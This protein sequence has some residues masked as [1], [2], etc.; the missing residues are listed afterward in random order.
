MDLKGLRWQILHGS[1]VK[2]LLVRAFLFALA[3]AIFP[4][5][6]IVH[7]MGTFGPLAATSDDCTLQ[8]GGDPH[9]FSS[10]FLQPM[11]ASALPF[12]KSS[13]S[14][15]CSENGNLTK[16]VFKELIDNN[17][18]DSNA[19]TLCVGKGSSLSVS[20]LRELG[21]VNSVGVD[22]H[23]FFSLVR[24]QFIYDLE[25]K[26]N[27]FDF[28]F[29]RDL[30]RVAIPAL[31]VVEVE[32]VLKPGGNGAMLVAS[33]S[34]K[35]GGLIKSAAPVSSFLRNSNVINVSSIDSSTLVIF[36]KKFDV[37]G[38]FENYRLPDKCP[39]ITRNKPFVK[40]M[41]P[42]LEANLQ[43]TDKDLSF[44]PNFL[45]I[46]SRNQ[47]IYINIG[48]GEFVNYSITNWFKP[49][50]PIKQA[51]N[52]YIVDHDTTTLSAYVNKPGITFV[53]YPGLAGNKGTSTFHSHG[54]LIAPYDNEVFDFVKWFKNIVGG[55]DFVVV[56]MNARDVELKLLFDLFE[57][58]A[59][60]RVDEL[61]LR[62]SDDVDCKSGRCGDCMSLFKGLRNSGIFVHQWWGP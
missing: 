11:S 62:C 27:S 60:C 10:G 59:I 52:V 7:D 21:L 53:Y 35:S 32:R 30:D 8:A 6:R 51:L 55:G 20:K 1:L 37:L 9:L 15:A 25:F 12:I 23:P 46:S 2:R 54:D 17:I 61:F 19:K 47:L 5:V 36:R 45:N 49:F 48:A 43:P 28:V 4:F 40:H 29:S 16:N 3:M 31:L 58:G 57:S 24:K 34:F 22:K 41:K 13:V 18:L 56:M 33:H 50:Y 26:D 39:A 42:L 44:L 14:S 38:S